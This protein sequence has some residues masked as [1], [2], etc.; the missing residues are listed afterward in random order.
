MNERRGQACLD[1]TS[2][3]FCFIPAA[4]VAPLSDRAVV[5]DGFKSQEAAKTVKS[6]TARA[7]FALMKKVKHRAAC[8]RVGARTKRLVESEVAAVS[9][10][11]TFGGVLSALSDQARAPLT[12]QRGATAAVTRSANL[13]RR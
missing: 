6:S 10:S 8:R 3:G 2:R 7:H 9:A 5:N 4:V 1:D 11:T 12:S 13:K